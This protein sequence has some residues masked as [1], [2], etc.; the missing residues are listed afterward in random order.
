MCN[1]QFLVQNHSIQCNTVVSLGMIIKIWQLLVSC[2][3]SLS[4]FKYKCI[5]DIQY[6]LCTNVYWN[7]T[8]FQDWMLSKCSFIKSI[9]KCGC[10]FLAQ[11]AT[12]NSLSASFLM[13]TICQT[14]KLSHFFSLFLFISFST[15]AFRMLMFYCDDNLKL[16]APAL[17]PRKFFLIIAIPTSDNIIHKRILSISLYHFDE[18]ERVYVIHQISARVSSDQPNE[19]AT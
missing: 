17:V 5:C 1:V 3:V 8:T 6:A 2:T 15:F 18:R 12:P 14:P 7:R 16:W 10:S 13:K 19:R 9:F 4:A 11:T